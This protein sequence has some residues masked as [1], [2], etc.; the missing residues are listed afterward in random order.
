MTGLVDLKASDGRIYGGRWSTPSGAGTAGV[1]EPATGRLLATVGLATPD[2]IRTATVAA[3]KAQPQWAATDPAERGAVLRRA[4]LL[5]QEHTAEVVEWL[6][7]EG[8]AV[9]PKAE[10]EVGSVLDELWTAAALP[11]QP[12]GQLLPDT[13]GRRSVARRI[14]LGV[15]G[16]ISPW[17]FPLLLAVRALAPALALGNA[18][19]LKP[20]L[21]TPISG[22]Q[23]IAALFEQAGLPYGVLHV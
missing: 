2:D 20:D 17:N 3:A 4:A 18:V 12:Y 6:I 23:V 10:H 21:N 15:V 9:R 11:T 5:L 8:G 16:V 1:L 13:A 14:P 22:G 19:V 7:R